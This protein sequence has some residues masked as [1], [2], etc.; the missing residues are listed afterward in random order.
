M[1]PYAFRVDLSIF[2]FFSVIVGGSGRLIGPVIGTAILY[3]VPNALLAD[4]ASYRLL[5]YGAV[6]LLIML[7]FPDGVVGTVE[8]A[9]RRYRTRTRVSGIDFKT[10]LRESVATPA[11]GLAP[12]GISIRRARKAY[13]KM[14]A[15]NNVDVTVTPGR[16]HAIVGPN[17]SGKTTLLN[18]IS[19]LARLDQGEITIGTVDPTR[20]PTHHRARLGLGRTFQTPRVFEDMSIWDNLRIGADSGAARHPSWLLQSLERHRARWGIEMPDTLSHSQRRLLEVLRVLAMDSKILLLDEPAAGL[21]SEERHD[22][23][24][25]LRMA[26]D[27][28]GRTIVLIEHDLGLVWQIADSITVLDAGEVVTTGLPREILADPRVRG[29]FAGSPPKVATDA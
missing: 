29:L 6:A 22:L 10:V 26:R 7:L 17:G 11:D 15:L 28:L 27:K 20:R 12:I 13:G 16:I 2:F 19:G 1:S 8:R 23:A 21:S 14:V 24:D 3:L 5:A 25:L 9:F 4:L 18:A